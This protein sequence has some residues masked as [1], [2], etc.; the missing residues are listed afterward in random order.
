M[1]LPA[2]VVLT[3]LTEHA[4]ERGSFTELFRR[5]WSTG[6]DPPQWNV[7]RSAAGVLRGV[8]LHRRH[9]DYLTLAAGRAVIGL[10][11]LRA[12]SETFGVSA[13]LELQARDRAI[14]IPHGVAHG[15]L[16]LEPSIHVYAVSHYFDPIDEL[17]CRFDDPTL[18]LDWPIAD[19]RVSPRDAGLPSRDH[20][21]AE[22]EE[23]GA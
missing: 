9:D 11:D 1:E 19:P 23:I 7:V 14:T 5:E 3:Q 17:G 2:G 20:L 22:L 8:H 15:F 18:G 21:L 16:F 13:L 12:E 6:I 10:H 4:D